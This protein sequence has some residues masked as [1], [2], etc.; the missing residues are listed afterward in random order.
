L[1]LRQLGDL[2]Y[3]K[4]VHLACSIGVRTSRLRENALCD[5]QALHWGAIV[6]VFAEPT[7]EPIG[8]DEG[9][10]HQIVDETVVARGP[11]ALG[12]RHCAPLVKGVAR[13]GTV[14]PHERI[15]DARQDAR[16]DGIVWVDVG[17]IGE[18]KPGLAIEVVGVVDGMSAIRESRPPEC[19]AKAGRLAMPR[20]ARR[21]SCLLT[22][23]HT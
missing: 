1:E 21:N 15:V 18:R 17:V 11:P 19:G 4:F 9:L 6:R 23:S 7:P 2:A 12:C 8:E 5:D 16:D 3:Q 22:P 14:L 13:P 20:E 10:L